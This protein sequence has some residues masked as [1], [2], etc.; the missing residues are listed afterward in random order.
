MFICKSAKL[1]I[2]IFKTI[3]INFVAEVLNEIGVLIL[4]ESQNKTARSP[5]KKDTAVKSFQFQ[6]ETFSTE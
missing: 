1:E 4:F 2:E 5:N 6:N 3:I